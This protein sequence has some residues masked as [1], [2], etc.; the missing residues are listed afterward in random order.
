MFGPTASGSGSADADENGTSTPDDH[1]DRVGLLEAELAGL[2][3]ALHNRAVIEQAMGILAVLRRC[4]P[5]EAFQLLVRL[6]Q[7]SNV[8]LHRIAQLLVQLTNGS[9]AVTLEAA[10]ATALRQ[11]EPPAPVPPAQ[12]QD[13]SELVEAAR[14]VVTAAAG[15]PGEGLDQAI[16]AL[17]R[18]LINRGWIAPYDVLAAMPPLTA[19]QDAGQQDAGPEKRNAGGI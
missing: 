19:H 2:R 13:D 12:P 11:A 1:V 6:S 17:C 5:E 7:V 10:L 9:D 4:T 15:P 14:L 3:R 18:L 16:K 8:K